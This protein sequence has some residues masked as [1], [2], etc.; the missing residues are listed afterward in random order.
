MPRDVDPAALAI[1]HDAAVRALAAAQL[2]EGC[3]PA[4]V[5]VVL[6][7]PSYAD[8]AAAGARLARGSRRADAD[9]GCFAVRLTREAACMLLRASDL[10]RAADRVSAAPPAGCGW[11]VVLGRIAGDRRN[12]AT[13]PLALLCDAC[14]SPGGHA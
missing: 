11:L 8:H 13:A 12:A 3:A 4:D 9:D 2:D 5:A 1:R 10:R 14:A 7:H 6:F